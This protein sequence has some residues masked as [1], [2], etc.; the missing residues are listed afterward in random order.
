MSVVGNGKIIFC[1]G[2]DTSL[3]YLLLDRV[4]KDM[5]K[6]RPT[7]V[8]S[9][10]KFTFSIFAEGYFSRLNTERRWLVFRDRDFDDF[11][12]E[13][14]ALVPFNKKTTSNLVLMTHRAC[15]ENYLLDAS[16]IHEYWTNCYAEQQKYPSMRWSYKDSP[17]VEAI[18]SWIRESA[19]ALRDYQAVRWSLA[20]LVNNG[21]N[22]ARI[23]TTWT[24]G[25][26]TLPISLELD[27]CKGNAVAMISGFHQAIDGVT[28]ES[29][30]ENL[31]KFLKKFDYEYN[32]FWR[33]EEYIIWFHGKDIQKE[34]Q[35]QKMP[36]CK[37]PISIAEYFKWAVNKIDINSYPDLLEL[38]KKIEEL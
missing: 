10:G 7:I 25:S 1:E 22:L 17:G 14:I 27:H 11:P 36:A 21:G 30:H 12:T 38:R 31:N 24:G 19:M 4:L 8:P 32:D 20:A 18:D 28:N 37:N 29:F 5:P 23:K 33:N 35:K 3:D 9:G 6:E 15:I 16:L 34:M 2:K 26:G 13:D